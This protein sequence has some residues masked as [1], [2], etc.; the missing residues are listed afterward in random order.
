MT[1]N[2]RFKMYYDELWRLSPLQR[3]EYIPNLIEI[4]EK[5][6]GIMDDIKKLIEV[7]EREKG[8]IVDKWNASIRIRKFNIR[9]ER[10]G[11]ILYGFSSFLRE[12]LGVGVNMSRMLVKL[13]FFTKKE[14]EVIGKTISFQN[15]VK[16]KSRKIPYNYKEMIKSYSEGELS[17]EEFRKNWFEEKERISVRV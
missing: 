14:V 13:C 15:L 4:Q 11:I 6:N 16:G 2:Y 12:R 1:I 17:R 9:L 5:L 8:S 3:I 7:K 10:E